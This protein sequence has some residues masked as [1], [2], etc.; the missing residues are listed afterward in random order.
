MFVLFVERGCPRVAEGGTLVTF[1]ICLL[2]PDAKHLPLNEHW[3]QVVLGFPIILALVQ[4]LFLLLYYVYDT[5]KGSLLKNDKV[6]A[7]IS[8]ITSIVQ[9]DA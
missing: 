5:P 1:S 6:Q 4:F 2:L 7:R 3:W 9:T 8:G